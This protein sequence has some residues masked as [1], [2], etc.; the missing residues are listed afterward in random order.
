LDKYCLASGQR[1]NREKSSIFFSKRCP[2]EI[3]GVKAALDVHSE[4]LNEKYLGTP[5]DVER[6]R[7]GAFK[8]LNGGIWKRIHGR[9]LSSGARIFSSNL[10][11]KPYQSSLWRA[12]NYQEE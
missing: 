8:Y 3:K 11:P 9:L 7:S 10:L 5:S 1:I 4:T 12:L 2:N 6:S